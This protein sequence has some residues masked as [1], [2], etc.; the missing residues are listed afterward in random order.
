MEVCSVANAEDVAAC[1]VAHLDKHGLMDQRL[2][3]A[4]DRREGLGGAMRFRAA[5]A[6]IATRAA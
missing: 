5:A 2:S 1:V 6:L 3:Q 4:R